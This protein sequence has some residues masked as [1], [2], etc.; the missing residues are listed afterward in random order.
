MQLFQFSF[1]FPFSSFGRLA[2]TDRSV[3][4]GRYGWSV[5]LHLRDNTVDIDGRFGYI[6]G[7]LRL[8]STMSVGSYHEAP[9]CSDNVLRTRLTVL[10]LEQS[11]A[12]VALAFLHLSTPCVRVLMCATLQGPEGFFFAG[13]IDGTQGQRKP[14][15]TSGLLFLR[16]S[17]R[18]KFTASLQGPAGFFFTSSLT[19]G[20]MRGRQMR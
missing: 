20:L 5:R 14:S 6:Y 9:N 2:L 13:S 12:D 10:Q 4:H 18:R 1:F 11:S 7:E 17:A 15:M 16:A 8:I 19:G 3:G